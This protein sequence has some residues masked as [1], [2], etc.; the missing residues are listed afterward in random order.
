V[1]VQQG[2]KVSFNVSGYDSSGV[3]NEIFSRTLESAA[4]ASV[5]NSSIG[6]IT[7]NIGDISAEQTLTGSVSISGTA[8]VGQTLAASA[9][10]LNG[11]GTI[12]YQ[13]LRNGSTISGATGSNYTLVSADE[14]ASIKVRVSRSGMSGSVES[15]SVGPVTGGS[16]TPGPGGEDTLTLA[17]APSAY[18]VYVTTSTLT[19]SSS[20]ADLS[21]DYV[22]V[23][24]SAGSSTATLYWISSN[25]NGTYN[26]LIYTGTEAKYQNSVSFS[27]GS[28]S[29]NW[30]S[31]SA[32]SS[33]SSA[34]PDVGSVTF[35]GGLP[36]GTWSIY[37]VPGPITTLTGYLA[38]MSNFVALGASTLTSDGA[39]TL[40]TTGAQG[41]FDPN[42]TYS[43]IYSGFTN[44]NDYTTVVSKYL[45]NVSFSGGD[46]TISVS[47]MSDQTN[48]PYN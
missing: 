48:L 42:G 32:A 15:T 24:S 17:N 40:V 8:Q 33:G 44:P 43:I 14:G 22:A 12:S 7:L 1:P 31:M 39:A 37:V 4:T 36:G 10:N 6:G 9:S 11:S 19:S 41:T 38:A 23:A 34:V 25:G 20:Y 45:N 28:A 2:E 5:S 16:E 18:A 30:N 13:W 29:L 21:S 47:A 46:A 35:S 27:N 26:V 3:G